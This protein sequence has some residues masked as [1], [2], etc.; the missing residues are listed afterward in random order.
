MVGRLSICTQSCVVEQ[1]VGGRHVAV[2]FPF[3][4]ESFVSG[5]NGRVVFCT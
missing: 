5:D 3:F 1:V 4:H 2:A